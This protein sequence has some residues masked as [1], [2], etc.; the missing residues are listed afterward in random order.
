M[1][2]DGVLIDITPPIPVSFQDGTGDVDAQFIP[3]VTRARGKFQPFN[4]PESPMIEYEWKIKANMSGNFKDITPFVRIPLTQQEP[5]MEGLSLTPGTLY[6]LVL[7]GTNAAG[8]QS[9]IETN[10][11][12][13]DVTPPF[14]EGNVVDVTN[15]TDTDDVDVAGDLEIIQAKWKCFDRESGINSQSLGIGTYSGGDNLKAFEDVTF[16]SQT[17][18]KSEMFYVKF[19]NVTILPKVRY[20]VTV[21]IINGAG[22]R[23][24]ITSDGI[25][26]DITPPTVASYYIKDGESG[27]DRN[28]TSERFT[29]TAHWEHAF[30]DAESGVVEYRAGLGTKP[31]VADVKA[32]HVLGSQTN[33]TVSG[34]LL[35]SGQVYY[36]TVVGCNGVGMCVNASSNGMTVDFVPPNPGKVITGLKGPPVL[37]QWISKSVWARWKWCSAD[38]RRSQILLNSSRCSE[39]SFYDIHSGISM[40]SISIISQENKKLLSP[41]RP[42]GTQSYS[43]RSISMDDGVYSVA[44]EATDKAGIT[45][46][47]FSNTFIVDSSPPLITLV[48]HHRYQVSLLFYSRRRSLCNNSL[49]NW[50]WNLFWCRRRREISNVL[51]T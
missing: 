22:L 29:F 40:F 5:L 50:G 9:I 27:K 43:G 6:R 4:D 28:F 12:K 37:Y 30:A 15:E 26:V 19:Y 17:I 23:K 35:E 38:E 39:D 49:Q 7:R 44:I 42:V 16:F 41:F 36:M 33:V 3:S 20:H 8:L 46:Q 31:G 21:R 18:E 51:S 34:L 32:L 2:S 25:L 14:C 48:Q 1:C 11:F 45:S 24:T 13:P 47:G 10:G